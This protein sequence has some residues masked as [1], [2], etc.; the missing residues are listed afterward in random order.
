MSE[1][2]SYPDGMLGVKSKDIFC[3]LRRTACNF[4]LRVV[5][6]LFGCRLQGEGSAGQERGDGERRKKRLA[7]EVKIGISKSR[8]GSTAVD[9][10]D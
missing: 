3:F 6:C 8:N 4:C 1:H 5:C 9:F 10:S 7:G 2:A